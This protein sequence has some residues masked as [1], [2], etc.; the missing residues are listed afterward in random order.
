MKKVIITGVTGQDGSLMADYLLSHTDY[1]IY[2]AIRRL[3]VDNHKN[4]LHLKK[5]PRFTLVN[6]DLNDAHSIRDVIIV[7]ESK[8]VKVEL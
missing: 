8:I 6:L 7:F 3:S 1:Q 5:E 4:I 2:G